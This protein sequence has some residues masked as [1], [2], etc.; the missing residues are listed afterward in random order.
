MWIL[1]KSDEGNE[2]MNEG[3]FKVIAEHLVGTTGMCE[4]KVYFQVRSRSNAC[5]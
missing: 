4:F 1:L 3:R 2:L 5:I